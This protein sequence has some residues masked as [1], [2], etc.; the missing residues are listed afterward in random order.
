MPQIEPF[1]TR[2]SHLQGRARTAFLSH[3]LISLNKYLVIISVISYSVYTMISMLLCRQ[4]HSTVWLQ[5]RNTDNGSL[6]TGRRYAKVCD[7]PW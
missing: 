6:L 1:D 3:L 5:T 4:K 2:Q 7:T